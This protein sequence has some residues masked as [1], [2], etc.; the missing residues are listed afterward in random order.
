VIIVI[1]AVVFGIGLSVSSISAQSQTEIPAWV[2]GVANFWVEGNIDDNEFGESLTFLIE[3]GIIK[4]NTPQA[5]NSLELERKI[6]QLES[7]N[8]NFK[9]E[10]AEMKRK[11]SQLE[12]ENKELRN[13]LSRSSGTQSTH[14]EPTNSGTWKKVISF[15]GSSSKT[16]D[17][18]K[19][20]TEKFRY[21][22][23]CEG[24]Q[25]YDLMAIT[26]SEVNSRG[27]DSFTGLQACP[28]S[29]ETTYVHEGKGEYYFD[30]QSA[31]I[32]KWTILVE[33]S[34]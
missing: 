14:S 1:I 19:I 10:Y 21:T 34:N 11:I 33:E 17:T 30:I 25:P 23:S 15:S 6:A 2:K 31:N 8:Y 5:D 12:S 29:S 22:W 32:S 4:V 26:L 13:E 3:Q 27:F 7:E 16:T 9:N 28:E 18:F 24:L 20:T